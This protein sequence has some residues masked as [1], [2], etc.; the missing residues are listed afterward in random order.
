[1]VS[2]ADILN[3]S[4][5]IVDDLAANVRLLERVLRDVGHA[6]ITSTMDPFE[7]RELHRK[8]RCNL[9]LLDIAIPA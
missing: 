5:L 7:V 4:I 1:M 2:A 9:I 6:S 3:A 8:N